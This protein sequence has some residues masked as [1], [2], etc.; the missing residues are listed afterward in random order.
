[1]AAPL[2]APPLVLGRLLR[3]SLAPS[4]LADIAAGVVLGAG[5]WP[6]GPAP[7]VLMLA[8]ACV[9]HGGMALNDWADRGEDARTRPGRPIPSGAIPART[10]LALA[11]VLLALGPL[12]AL[13]AAPRCGLVLGAVALVAALYD[14]AGR[15][16]WLGPLLLAL[17][18][19]GNLG[20]GLALASTAVPWRPW[21]LLAPCAYGL[22]LFLVSRLAR[23]EDVEPEL[24]ARGE[25]RPG[26]WVLSAGLALVLV[27]AASAFL[28]AHPGNPGPDRYLVEL[29]ETLRPFAIATLG[30]LGLFHGLREHGG[31]PWRT[32]E[33]QRLAGMAL[34]RLLV[35]SSALACGA[36]TLD[37]LAV[38]LLILLGYPLSFALRKVF[39]PT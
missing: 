9:Y 26:A 24:L 17:C 18:R 20:A 3:L 13:A 1:M 8:S 5:A 33:V 36:G 14:L 19:A 34:R 21:L 32:P 29:A 37:G 27:G 38:A 28:A 11:V 15:G 6:S 12:L 22:Y 25:V 16:P 31:T 10:A 39:P 7:F 4:A 30:A 23:L 35:C 2:L